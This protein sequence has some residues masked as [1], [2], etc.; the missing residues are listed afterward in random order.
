MLCNMYNFF[1]VTFVMSLKFLFKH[2]YT[3]EQNHHVPPVTACVVQNEFFKNR[4]QKVLNGNFLSAQTLNE[5]RV[6]S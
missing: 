4:T 5:V 2:F 6:T 3:S 1:H